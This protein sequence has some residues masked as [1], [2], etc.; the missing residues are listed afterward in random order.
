MR[1]IFQILCL[2]IAL[3]IMD[4][5]FYPFTIL[6]FLAK[7]GWCLMFTGFSECT[8]DNSDEIKAMEEVR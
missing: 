2:Y 5:V 1:N 4:Y 3:Q 7:L 6:A 8:E